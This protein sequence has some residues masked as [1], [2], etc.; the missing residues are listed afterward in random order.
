MNKTSFQRTKH[1]TKRNSRTKHHSRTKHPLPNKTPNKTSLRCRTKHRTKQNIKQAVP[2]AVPRR[3]PEQP[4][5]CSR[6]C[7][8]LLGTSWGLPRDCWK[9]PNK[10]PNKTSAPTV[11]NTQQ[12]KVREL[13]PN[14][15]PNT[16][17]LSART[18]NAEQN[19]HRTKTK[20]FP[21]KTPNT[22]H[23]S[24]NTE[25]RSGPVLMLCNIHLLFNVMCWC[26]FWLTATPVFVLPA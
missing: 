15:T 19:K 20:K 2:R 1:R 18:L 25:H 4:L 12:N 14:K 9:L 26:C 17:Q 22:E 8:R 10:T 21:N 3:F 7:W 24:L 13:P 23:C 11:Q 5:S 6:D 16:D